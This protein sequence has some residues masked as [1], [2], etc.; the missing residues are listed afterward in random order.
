MRRTGLLPGLCWVALTTE[1]IGRQQ[2]RLFLFQALHPT[3]RKWQ[4][5]CGGNAWGLGARL[6]TLAP[7]LRQ[8]GVFQSGEGLLRIPMWQMTQ[9]VV[10]TAAD[11]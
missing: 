2:L 10:V 1:A 3:L 8:E 9:R 7:A 4:V 6:L 5:H 11:R